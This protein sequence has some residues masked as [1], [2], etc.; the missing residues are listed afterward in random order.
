MATYFGYVEREANS[1]VNWADVG[2]TITNTVDEIDRVRT[3][4]KAAIDA[5][6]KD[7]LQRIN[8][9]PQ[10][11]NRVLN[12]FSI[13]L[14][15][16]QA[17]NLKIQNNLLKS[18]KLSPKDFAVYL[19]NTT[20]DI[21]SIYGTLTNAQQVFKEKQDRMKANDSQGIEVIDAID[22]EKYGNFADLQT[23][24][25]INGKL[26]FGVTEETIVDGQKVRKVKPG[27]EN[28][29]SVDM[30][31][32]AMNR[33]YDRY[34][35]VKDASGFVERLGESIMSYRTLG[36]R[37]KAGTITEIV[38][39]TGELDL[40][41]AAAYGITDP[42]EIERLKKVVADFQE[43]EGKYIDAS[44]SEYNMS[45][46]ITEELNY[47]AT[48]DKTLAEKDPKKYM[49]AER[50]SNGVIKPMPTPEQEAEAE[51][52]MRN[53][54]RQMID[55]KL[56][57]KPYTDA[58][59]DKPVQQQSESAYRASGRATN[60]GTMGTYIQKLWSGDMDTK[61]NTLGTIQGE[62]GVS[63]GGTYF[64][65][66]A[67]G[68]IY[69]RVTKSALV[70]PSMPSKDIR[71]TNSDGSPYGDL[72]TFG[73][74]AASWIY[75][76]K[77]SRSVLSENK[78]QFDAELLKNPN[79]VNFNKNKKQKELWDLPKPEAESQSPYEQFTSEQ[80]SK[81]DITAAVFTT[82]NET[83]ASTLTTILQPY[84]ITA[85]ANGY[86][87]VTVEIPGYGPLQLKSE[88]GKVDAQGAKD[89]V[90]KLLGTIE[91]YIKGLKGK[92]QGGGGSASQN[93]GKPRIKQ[94]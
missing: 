46:I 53:Q 62:P 68:S 31:V 61:Q 18:G 74:T 16:N 27:Q 75:G 15:Y 44:L 57:I 52:F 93:G 76:D 88:Y 55:K 32:G 10:G 45:S 34:D 30:L 60:A 12:E 39:K 24:S 35:Y 77:E 70:D 21:E 29:L 90:T 71:M 94:E 56:N 23:F 38:D 79:F 11:E 65:T 91:P 69:L 8:D 26:S 85:K 66:G 84:G 92:G 51:N 81:K 9:I 37:M 83:T 67:D 25:N 86:Y 41:K 58:A 5:A 54:M 17:E 48:F 59:Q 2:R 78:K 73:E 82:D 36:D 80:G 47:E 50:Q 7:G 72:Q 6:Y 40:V 43:A 19:Q 28:I 20:D 63:P 22:L 89:Q 64:V 87:G 1:Y 4:K 33:K 14:G 49:Y 42:A 13:N 3:E